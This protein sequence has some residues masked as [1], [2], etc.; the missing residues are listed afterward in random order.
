MRTTPFAGEVADVERREA[1]ETVLPVVSESA[2]SGAFWPTLG[3]CAEGGRC[4][5]KENMVRQKKTRAATLMV[6]R[7]GPAILPRKALGWLNAR[8]RPAKRKIKPRAKIRKLAQ[9]IS[10]VTGY[11]AKMGM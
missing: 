3:A 9:G 2:K 4:L 11:F 5:P 6:A 1:S 10:R 7:M 8:R